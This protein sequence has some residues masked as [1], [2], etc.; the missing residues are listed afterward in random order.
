MENTSHISLTVLFG[1]EIGS[2]GRKFAGLEALDSVLLL[3]DTFLERVKDIKWTDIFSEASEAAG[4]L[5]DIKLEDILVNAWK[6]HQEIKKYSDR[7]KYPPE[8]TILCPLG[9][10]RIKSVHH[11]YLEIYVNDNPIGRMVFDLILQFDLEG[12]ILKIR[13]AKIIEILAGR[14]QGSGTFKYGEATLLKKESQKIPIP[15][16]I[17]L[18]NGVPIV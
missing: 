8:E 11:P 15:G 14:C 5:L 12:F 1:D 3:K 13:D 10:H 16:H 2:L 18:G 7:E 4:R 6:K 17:A 9:H